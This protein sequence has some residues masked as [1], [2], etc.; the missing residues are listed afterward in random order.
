VA[1][2]VILSRLVISEGKNLEGGAE[3]PMAGSVSFKTSTLR[4]TG[5]TR[6]SP[7]ARRR[8]PPVERRLPPSWP[9][10]IYE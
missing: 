6:A 9:L 4:Q 10:A 7:L 3:V 5:L 2:S 8:R 1:H